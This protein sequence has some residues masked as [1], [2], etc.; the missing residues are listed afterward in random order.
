MQPRDRTEWS[1][2]GALLAFG[3]LAWGQVQLEDTWFYAATG[4]WVVD[5]HAIP[6]SDPFSWTVA[7]RPWQS[8]GWL[9]G[10][11][12]W[13]V[14][15]LGSF[16]AIA[17]LKPLYVVASGATLRWASTDFG[18]RR[19]PAMLGALVGT[20]AT[21]PFLVERPQLASYLAVPVALVLARRAMVR[22]RPWLWAGLLV[23]VFA[24]W[25]N[26][27]SV[28]LTGVPLV[29]ALCFGAALDRRSV[30]SGA[31]AAAVSLA[32]LCGTLVNPWGVGVW[33]HATQVRSISRGTISEW[34][35]LWRSGVGGWV[36]LVV[37]VAV[38]VAATRLG[39]LRRLELLGPLVLAALLAVDAI[40]S[41]PLFAVAAGVLV[42]PLVP[43]R[44]AMS[45]DRKRTVFIGAMAM[46]VLSFVLAIPRIGSSGE[47]ATE[48]PVGP[49][50]A[51]PGGCR[52]LNDYTFG[53]WVMFD[54]P[55]VPVSDDG[56][57]DLYGQDDAR[58][59]L[60][61][62]PAQAEQLPTWARANE[63]DC[64]LITPGSPARATLLDAGWHVLAEDP[65]AVALTSR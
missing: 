25:T 56:R 8:N 12:L 9:W 49:V 19:G 45:P 40:R 6:R 53:N 33:T 28:A 20:I 23:V 52:L 7:G 21:F 34:E 5:H 26:L 36:A 55:D 30:R 35:P 24:V 50:A 64:A 11:L 10:L 46:L 44:P 54:R 60:L 51:L 13:A 38:T 43:V 37:V 3:L 31:L 14:W 27:H 65:N 47:P 63:V 16:A 15:S 62:D 29:A 59:K 1:W 57:N 41:F 48:T 32:A 2:W 17:A 61:H 18:A 58:G 4:R 42:T 22:R 39:G